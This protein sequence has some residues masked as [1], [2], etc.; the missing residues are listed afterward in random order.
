[1]GLQDLRAVVVS[2][3]KVCSEGIGQGHTSP[4]GA[5]STSPQNCRRA[6]TLRSHIRPSKSTFLACNLPAPSLHCPA[7]LFLQLQQKF[8][9]RLEQEKH[10]G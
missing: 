9:G 3:G 2:T 10:S 1:M 5:L 4:P 8:S 6:G 7:E